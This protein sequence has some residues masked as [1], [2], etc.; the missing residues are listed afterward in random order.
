VYP[1]AAGR[2][3]VG[4]VDSACWTAAGQP[5]PAAPAWGMWAYGGLSAGGAA[6][7]QQLGR[8][9]VLGGGAATI[10]TGGVTTG[11]ML[12]PAGAPKQ[13]RLFV[14]GFGGACGGLNGIWVLSYIN[15]CLWEDSPVSTTWTLSGG[16]MT[17]T[18]VGHAGAN[19]PSYTRPNSTWACLAANVLGL[20][21]GGGCVG[22][23]LTLTVTPY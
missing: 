10:I 18:L 13:W 14:A 7:A 8:G 16:P 9:G 6:P 3:L 20:A 2:T 5:V 17:W 4:G 19:S 12:C 15:T 21:A 1:P 23:P 11:C 22:P